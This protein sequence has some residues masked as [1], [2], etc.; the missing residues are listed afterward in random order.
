[1]HPVTRAAPRERLTARTL[2]W[3]EILGI[4]LGSITYAIDPLNFI[5]PRLAVAGVVW[6]ATAAILVRTVPALLKRP[7][8]SRNL[9]IGALLVYATLLTASTGATSSPFISLYTLPLIGSGLLWKRWQVGLLALSGIGLTLVQSGLLDAMNDMYLL[10]TAAIIVIALAPGVAAAL[11][12]AGLQGKIGDV[13]QQVSELAARDSLTGLLNLQ[14]FET[15]LEQRHREADGTGQTYSVVIVDVDDIRQLNETLGHEAGSQMIVT[16]AKA[17]TRSIRTSD[18]AARM[19]GD[20][21]I[22][23]LAEADQAMA[24]TI[25][26]RIRNNVYSGTLMVENRM[27]RA[28]V[29]IGAASFPRDEQ[30]PKALMILADQ[31]MEQ[32]KT[33]RRAPAR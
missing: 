18:Y 19:G 24:N 16:V 12:L 5:H 3:L 13:E 11:V 29:S 27:V 21:F 23:L 31:R 1:M 10:T 17:V 33:L 8:A 22:L 20:V 2:L 9:E 6:M 25:A 7:R 15:L 28:T 4:A 30:T 14:A 32:D 26:L